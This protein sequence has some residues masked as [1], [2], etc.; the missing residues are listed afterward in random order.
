MQI[1]VLW[2]RQAQANGASRLASLLIATADVSRDIVRALAS[3]I[4]ALKR[5]WA[6]A[7]AKSASIV[8]V[9]LSKPTDRTATRVAELQAHHTGLLSDV[10]THIASRA[11]AQ[12]AGCE[13]VTNGM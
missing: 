6:S 11:A 8:A 10:S 13:A 4:R 1:L 5:I 3:G 7:V 2:C 12:V 9:S